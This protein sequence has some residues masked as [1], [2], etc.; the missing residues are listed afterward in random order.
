M[1]NYFLCHV[2]MFII[3]T[4]ADL[5]LF[6][7]VFFLFYKLLKTKTIAIENNREIFDHDK[8]IWQLQEE[9]ENLK[10]VK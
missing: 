7:T 6:S 3:S 8:T 10:K 2:W 5:I 4:I 9:I 1:E